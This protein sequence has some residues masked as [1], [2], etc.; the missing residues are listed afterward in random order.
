MKQAG[1]ILQVH[2]IPIYHQPY[3]KKN[4]DTKKMFLF[5]KFLFSRS[6]TTYLLFIKTERSN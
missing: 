6:F 1:F 2:Y 4:M 3:Y 5:R